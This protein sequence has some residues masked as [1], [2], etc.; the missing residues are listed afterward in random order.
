M[1][2]KLNPAYAE[3]VRET[4]NGC[5][6]FRHMSM[7]LREL[8]LGFAIVDLEVEARHLQAFGCV[9]GG[10]YAAAIDTAAFWAPFC[11]LAEGTGITTVDLKVNYLA[12]AGQGKITAAGKRIKLG[13]TLGL[14]EATVTDSQGKVLAHGSSTIIVIPGFG[15]AGNPVLPPKFLPR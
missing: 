7:T 13:K 3:A 9:H 2:K 14:T 4:V 1:V 8:G 12:P 11:E 15:L 5:P 6:F 10:V